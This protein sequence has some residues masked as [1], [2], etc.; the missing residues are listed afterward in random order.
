M[1]KFNTYFTTPPFWESQSKAEFSVIF[2]NSSSVNVLVSGMVWYTVVF[3]DSGY[4]TSQFLMTIYHNLQQKIT[5]TYA[6][7]FRHG[8][9]I[10]SNFLKM[11]CR[12]ESFFFIIC[13][14]NNFVGF[15]VIQCNNSIFF[16][17]DF[18]S[19]SNLLKNRSKFVRQYTEIEIK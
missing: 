12:F 1:L 7:L 4:K 6:N 11:T 18:F 5:I 15:F 10:P 3:S 13:F 9:F 14:T 19:S 2:R 8:I 17:D 16:N